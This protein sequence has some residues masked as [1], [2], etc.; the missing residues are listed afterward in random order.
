MW[1]SG[2]GLLFCIPQECHSHFVFSRIVQCTACTAVYGV[3]VF[4]EKDL[5]NACQSSLGRREHMIFSCSSLVPSPH[6][7]SDWGYCST[8][9]VFLLIFYTVSLTHWDLLRIIPI[10][11]VMDPFH[12][13]NLETAKEA[14]A[15]DIQLLSA[16]HFFL[17]F[18][19]SFP[20][21]LQC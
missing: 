2:A 5:D 14:I 20:F 15:D 19:L 10:G 17:S 8:Q 4:Y 11:F 12:S 16:V 1:I 9:T 3:P 13:I 6:P 21:P 7:I 18:S